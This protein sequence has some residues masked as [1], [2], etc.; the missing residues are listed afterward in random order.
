M[1]VQLDN[2]G[3]PKNWPLHAFQ[4]QSLLPNTSLP[5]PFPD[6]GFPE[7]NI[8]RLGEGVF[9]DVG[10]HE[11]AEESEPV[12][13]NGQWIRQWSLVDMS[14]EEQ[15]AADLNEAQNVRSNRNEILKTCDWTQLADS[16]LSENA[17]SEWSQ[18]RQALRDI[19][20]N[21][22]FPWDVIWPEVPV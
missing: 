8:Y 14:P 12:L 11:K 22:G 21:S 16:P 10:R 9:P 4:V 19:P 5:V 6:E 2:Q 20:G 18:Y 15:A 1:F 3:A 17:K 7:H 13:E